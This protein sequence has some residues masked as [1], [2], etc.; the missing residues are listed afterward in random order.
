VFLTML[1]DITAFVSLLFGYFFFWTIHPDFPPVPTPGPGVLWPSIALVLLLGSWLLTLLGRRL[2]HGG[3]TTAFVVVLLTASISA[4]AGVGALVAGP[5]T[6][7]LDP[8]SHIYP[9]V[10]W[11]V[12][13]WTAV[14]VAV[15]VIMLLYCVARS[16]AGHL[17]ARHDID[18][19]N[20]ALY[21]HFAAIT[22]VMTVA[23]LAGFP[24]VV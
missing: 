6:T 18:I 2:N 20:V 16:L 4:L 11:V 3:N 9:A 8:A 1:A 22:S 15:G 5:W 7:G 21:W 14:H 10:V 17:T 12:V 23:V 13:I 24:L 19:C